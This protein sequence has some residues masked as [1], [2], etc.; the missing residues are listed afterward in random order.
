MT[1]PGKDVSRQSSPALYQLWDVI[2]VLLSDVSCW[3]SSYPELS[4][5]AVCRG[6]FT[7]DASCLLFG[8]C[9]SSPSLIGLGSLFVSSLYY[10]GWKIG[11]NVLI[12]TAW[13]PPPSPAASLTA[14]LKTKYYNFSFHFNMLLRIVKS[15]NV[16]KVE[17]MI[18][19]GS[20]YLTRMEPFDVRICCNS[21]H[22]T[23][24]RVTQ[25]RGNWLLSLLRVILSLP[26]HHNSRSLTL[27]D[28]DLGQ[29]TQNDANLI[30]A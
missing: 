11:S 30:T 20:N 18:F 6:N 14:T 26:R 13:C 3:M 15:A 27:H 16:L 17:V 22:A 7:Q 5:G 10:L 29:Q 28:T 21:R 8:W 4:L 19:L 24:A 25:I 9:W 23:D 1:S 2:S 12:M